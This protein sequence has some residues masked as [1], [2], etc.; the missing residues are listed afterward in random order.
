MIAK[1]FQPW[2]ASCS[3]IAAQLTW[4]LPSSVCTKE[5][6]CAMIRFILAESVPD[7]EIHLRL[8]EQYEN[9]V[10]LQQSV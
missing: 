9:S 5:E 1:Y 8:S 4:P 2:P 7:A 6:Q 3:V 10:L